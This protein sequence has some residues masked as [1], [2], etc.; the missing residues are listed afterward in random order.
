MHT[1]SPH[2]HFVSNNQTERELAEMKTTTTTK[3]NDLFCFTFLCKTSASLSLLLEK[4]KMCQT[5]AHCHEEEQQM[6]NHL[7]FW[8]E[9]IQLTV[10]FWPWTISIQIF[11]SLISFFLLQNLH[12]HIFFTRSKSV[13]FAAFCMFGSSFLMLTVTSVLWRKNMHQKKKK[14]SMKENWI[15]FLK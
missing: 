1:L 11:F 8:Q 4:C 9:H 15:E 13:W 2:L 12:S 14:S 3:R 7:I 6:L 10:S 5:F